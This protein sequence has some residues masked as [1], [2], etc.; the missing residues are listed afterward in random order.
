MHLIKS[1]RNNWLT[2]KTKEMLFYDN[3][4][5]KIA[6]W[7]HLVTLYTLES[8]SNF[9]LSKLNEVAVFPK[10]IERQ[11][12]STCLR[13]FCE[14]TATAL[15]THPGMLDVEGRKET[16]AFIKLVIKFWKIVNVKGLG[17]DVRHNDPCKQLCVTRQMTDSHF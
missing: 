15:L 16:A 17:A 10:P 1:F 6:K 14:E 4:V 9:R 8:S 5:A 3:G 2:E 7:S 13:I 11:K 12:V